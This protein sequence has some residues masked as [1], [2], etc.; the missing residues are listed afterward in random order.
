AVGAGKIVESIVPVTDYSGTGISS[1]QVTVNYKSSLQNDLLGLTRDKG[2]KLKLYVIYNDGNIDRAIE[3]NISLQDCACC[4]ANTKAATSNDIVW[5]AFMCHN[6]GANEAADPFTPAAAIHG[7]KYKWGVK[8][9]ALTQADDQAK[10]GAITSPTAWVDIAMPLPTT[11]DNWNMV[12][13][14]PCPPGWRVPTI[15]EWQSVIDNNTIYRATDGGGWSTSTPSW[16]SGANVFGNGIKFGDALVL[17]TAGYRD[18]S[19]GLLVN[20][21]DNGYYWSSTAYGSTACRLRF[22]SGDQYTNNYPY[23]R[24]CGFSVR[25]ISE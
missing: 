20:R 25:C 4:G 11:S 9:V 18:Y 13:Q 21:G 1:A 22:G 7:A 5:R 2:L 6:L 15:E 19:N 24:T 17:P 10:P 16:S 23:D 14:N 8:T 12:T 3:L